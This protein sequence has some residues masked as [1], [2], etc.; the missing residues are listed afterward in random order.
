MNSGGLVDLRWNG[1]QGQILAQ[2][3]PDGEGNFA[4]VANI[5][6]VDAGVY[7]IMVTEGTR[8]TARSA[9]E[10]TSASL[11]SQSE[12]ALP[13][14]G[15]QERSSELWAGFSSPAPSGMTA[16]SP[17]GAQAATSRA[18]LRAGVG[19]LAFGLTALLF[20]IGALSHRKIRSKMS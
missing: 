17:S 8:G 3:L 2:A 12:E 15:F 9:F 11:N 14:K 19:M 16:P 10:V 1:A 7:S 13:A 6:E 18:G 20:G 5:P 4:L